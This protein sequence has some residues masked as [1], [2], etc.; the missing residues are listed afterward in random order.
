MPKARTT[1]KYL[2]CI[3]GKNAKG[4]IGQ[5]ESGNFLKA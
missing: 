2:K 5:N 3:Q 1:R 4:K